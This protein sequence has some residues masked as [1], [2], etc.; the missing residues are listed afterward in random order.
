MMRLVVLF[1]LFLLYAC[2]LKDAG[3][4][5]SET[6]GIAGVVGVD[7]QHNAKKVSKSES[8]EMDSVW[9]YLEKEENEVW[10][11]IDSQ[12]TAREFDF[13]EL[14]AGTYR[15]KAST[16][17]ENQSLSSR[18]YLGWSHI[19]QLKG[20]EQEYVELY[21]K[22]ARILRILRE[23]T[24]D[25]DILW[26]RSDNAGVWVSSGEEYVT[27]IYIESD[28]EIQ[29]EFGSSNGTQEYTIQQIEEIEGNSVQTQP[30]TLTEISS[31]QN[32]SSFFYSSSSEEVYSYASEDLIWQGGMGAQVMTGGYWWGRADS[33][34]STWGCGGENYDG[35]DTGVD[36]APCDNGTGIF[37]HLT[38]NAGT[39]QDDDW[40]TAGMGFNFLDDGGAMIP[41]AYSDAA[42]YEAICVDYES[43]VSIRVNAMTTDDDG[44]DWY[45][46]SLFPSDTTKLLSFA[47]ARQEGWSGSSWSFVPSNMYSLL[48]LLKEADQNNPGGHDL[49]I[50]QVYFCSS[51]GK[52]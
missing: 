5:T 32:V 26:A 50:K 20:G 24:F 29:V 43:E 18:E 28:E 16:Y 22:I 41:P 37:T 44:E 45:G 7:E 21:I 47:S 49:L 8:S 1:A 4:V 42:A 12:Y 6:G 23:G 33:F 34:G 3:V 13:S 30:E 11:R 25:E 39:T 36:A 51:A 48:F 31:E 46:W 52:K 9:V 27:L 38:I 19:I 10:E 17:E 2:S 14:Q 40:G 35:L 15:L